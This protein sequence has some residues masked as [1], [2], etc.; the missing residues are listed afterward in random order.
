VNLSK[1]LK[2]MEELTKQVSGKR[3]AIKIIFTAKSYTNIQ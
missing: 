3:R 1:E 2:E